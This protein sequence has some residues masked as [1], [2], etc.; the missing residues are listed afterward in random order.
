MPHTDDNSKAILD[1]IIATSENPLA[2]IVANTN[3]GK[4]SAT[5]SVSTKRS[6]SNS[7]SL[8][9][10]TT[11]RQL[12]EAIF[13]KPDQPEADLPSSPDNESEGKENERKDPEKEPES[14][15]ER[16]KRQKLDEYERPFLETIVDTD[17]I[18][19]DFESVHLPRT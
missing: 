13:S 14:I 1:D 10:I 8:G 19:T 4:S 15:V 17:K 16:V 2:D 11:F 6:R 9:R 3:G 7:D 18:S 5:I 12:L